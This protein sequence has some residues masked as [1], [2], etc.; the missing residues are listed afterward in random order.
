MAYNATQILSERAM[1]FYPISIGTSLA[2][3]SI[4]GIA[5]SDYSDNSAISVQPSKNP[6]GK[7]YDSILFNIR[8]LVRNFI[9]SIPNK[10]VIN[11]NVDDIALSLIGE[12][13]YCDEL[14]SRTLGHLGRIFYSLDYT[15]ISDSYPNANHKTL[16]TDKQIH[17][18]KLE[19]EC[20]NAIINT[21]IPIDKRLYRKSITDSFNRAIVLTHMSIDL[22]NRHQF[23]LL[24]LLESHTGKLKTRNEWYTKFGVSNK[25]ELINIPLVAAT[26]QL[27]GDGGQLFSPKSIGL[28][29]AFLEVGVRGKWIYSTTIEKMK[30]DVTRY[31]AD[32]DIRNDLLVLF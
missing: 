22:L 15:T 9:N 28:R 13:M 31:C 25:D 8:T 27:F 18:A 5:P 24:V 19:D 7:Q 30:N 20:V 14:L 17:H 3:E 32:S 10:E 16:Q 4:L 21:P 1:G 23:A 26:L 2:I 11:L 12:L 29:K 6:P